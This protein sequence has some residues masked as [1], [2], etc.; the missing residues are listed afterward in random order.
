[1]EFKTDTL[2]YEF[3]T[4]GN[5]SAIRIAISGSNE[6]QNYCNFNYRIVPEDLDEGVTL[7]DLSRKKVFSVAMQ[8]IKADITGQA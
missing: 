8:R 7:D 4:E 6:K 2:S 1:M 5:T 3:D